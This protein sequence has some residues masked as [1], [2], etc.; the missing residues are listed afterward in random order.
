[1]RVMVIVKATQNSEAGHLPSDDLLTKM[2]SDGHWEKY[3]DQYLG[4]VEGLPKAADAKKNLPP[5][6]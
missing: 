6:A 4:K 2:L 3:Y 1:M 5:A